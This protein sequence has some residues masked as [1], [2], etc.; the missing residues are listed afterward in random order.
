MHTLESPLTQSYSL[1]S[2]QARPS[3]TYSLL[4]ER[5]PELAQQW[6]P[7]KNKEH[8]LDM[9]PGNSTFVAWWQCARKHE[10]PATIK[11]RYSKHS[12]CR[13]CSLAKVERN[14]RSFSDRRLSL[15]SPDIAATWHPT[16]ND[17]LTPDDVTYSSRQRIWWQC[18][19][20]PSHVWDTTVNN[21]QRSGCPF[22]AGVL[23]RETDPRIKYEAPLSETHPTLAHEWHPTRNL[24]LTPEQVTAGSKRKIWWQCPVDR[25]HHWQMSLNYRVRAGGQCADCRRIRK[26]IRDL[27]RQVVHHT[28][29]IRPQFP[30]KTP[31][32]PP[33]HSENTRSIIPP[34]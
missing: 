12:G 27:H 34:A 26:T 22:C 15:I 14:H 4:S 30:A 10:W 9:F 21:R 19:I 5:R 20:R 11:S 18:P 7:T 25:T 31:L 33:L 8:Q 17:P 3:R 6:H 13:R 2:D 32:A 29:L 1:P 24:P 23:I 28:P 16:K